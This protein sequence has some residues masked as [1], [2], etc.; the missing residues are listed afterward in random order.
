MNKIEKIATLL[1]LIAQL[2][3]ESGVIS[4]DYSKYGGTKLNIHLSR[5][6]FKDF[7]KKYETLKHDD[8]HDRLV[9]KVGDVTVMA[10]EDK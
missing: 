3:E 6:E 8:E 2:A 10:L 1:E 7:F 5:R 9:A 4:T